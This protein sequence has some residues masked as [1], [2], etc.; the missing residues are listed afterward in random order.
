MHFAK[1]TTGGTRALVP[2]DRP[3]RLSIDHDIAAPEGPGD[4]N[5]SSVFAS[6]IADSMIIKDVGLVC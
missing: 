2:C 5:D 4:R 3:S 1:T 6:S